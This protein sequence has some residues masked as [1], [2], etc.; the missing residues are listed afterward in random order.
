VSVENIW[1]FSATGPLAQANPF[2]VVVHI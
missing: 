1:L 2:L